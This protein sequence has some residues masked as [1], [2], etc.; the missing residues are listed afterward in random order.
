MFFQIVSSSTENWTDWV[1]LSSS[2]LGIHKAVTSTSGVLHTV[3]P[4]PGHPICEPVSFLLFKYQLR[5]ISVA[6]L[7]YAT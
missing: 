4:L 6:Y 2:Y 1:D 7:D 3:L 5:V